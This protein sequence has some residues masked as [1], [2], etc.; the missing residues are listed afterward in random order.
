MQ[1]AL[2]FIHRTGVVTTLR[3]SANILLFA[4]SVV[5]CAA[6]GYDLRLPGTDETADIEV[7]RFDRLESRYLQNGDFSALQQ[8]ETDYP[9]ETRTLIE[10]ILRIGTVEDQDINSKFLAFYQDSVLQTLISDA[11]TEY[12][13]MDDIS[14]RLT[15]VFRRLRSHVPTIDVPRVYAQITALD[16][17]ILIDDRSIAISIEKYLG[18]DYALYERYY[19]PEQRKGMSRS[20]IVPD[21]VCFYLMS[22]YPL[23]DFEKTSQQERDIHVGKIMWVCNEVLGEEVF[24]SKYVDIIAAYVELNDEATVADLLALTDYSPLLRL[25]D[26]Q[27]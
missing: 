8:M 1:F 4:A 14:R 12:A 19:S 23:D 11:E 22:L 3:Q 25:L 21:C 26:G 2:S 13:S 24:R 27:Q 20:N 16:Q 6:C 15:E 9:M 17:S 7:M 18:E 5:F 10:D